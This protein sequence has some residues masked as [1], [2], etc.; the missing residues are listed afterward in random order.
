MIEDGLV[1]SA[2]AAVALGVSTLLLAVAARR[3]G[4]VVATSATL[5][6]AIVPLGIAAAL[7]DFSLRLEWRSTFVL[8]CAGSLV[9][10]AYLAAIESVRLGPVAIT[11]PIGSSAG[12]GTVAAAFVLL[13][14]R[15]TLG[16]WAGVVLAALGVVLAS[17]TRTGEGVR[18]AGLGPVYAVVGVILGSVANA[19]VRDPV[20]DL[21]PLQAIVTQRIAT[22][23]VVVVLV[24]G[25]A[26]LTVAMRS[27]LVVTAARARRPFDRRLLALLLA[28]GLVDALAFLAFGYALV[29]TP[30]WLVGV[31]SQSGR[32][33]A[34]VGGIV[35]F[36]ERPS[37]IQWTGIAG[38][39]AGLVVLAAFSS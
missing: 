14:E 6:L 26:A 32:A 28:L 27:S 24:A 17:L 29:D 1:L 22:V 13:G 18:L 15:P 36:R 21:G 20:R 25:A 39:G 5:V 23:A 31:V 33:L 12:A 35:L 2:L 3:I 19:I 9:A 7:T 37:G 4:T 34:V 30:A 8:F 38:L 11:S 10:V 16:Q